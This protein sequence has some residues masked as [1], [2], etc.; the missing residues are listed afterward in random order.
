VV[1]ATAEAEE[2]WTDI[3]DKLSANSLFRKGDSWIFGANVPGKKPAVMF[4]FGGLGK[5]RSVLD[6][7]IKAGYK[8]FLGC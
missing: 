3:C 2:E 8:G 4:Y 1:E 6:D 5:Y 7:V